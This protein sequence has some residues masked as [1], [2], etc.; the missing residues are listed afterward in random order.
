MEDN[1]LLQEEQAEGMPAVEEKMLTV[2]GKEQTYFAEIG[3]WSLVLGIFSAIYLGFMVLMGVVYICVGIISPLENMGSLEGILFG[4]FFFLLAFLMFFPT[5]Y[6]INGGKKLR[7]GVRGKNQ[8]SFSEGVANT[9]SFFKFSA[10]YCI[11][12]IPFSLIV[13]IVAALIAAL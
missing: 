6:L 5:K 4:V 12:V 8:E 7:T 11:A 10:I 13:G 3:Q 9:K 1:R 2:G